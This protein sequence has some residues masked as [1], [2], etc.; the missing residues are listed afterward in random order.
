LLGCRNRGR[1]NPS[2]SRLPRFLL[3]NPNPCHRRRNLA[4]G[5]VMGSWGPARR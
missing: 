5:L 3:C 1:D 2:P 4:R